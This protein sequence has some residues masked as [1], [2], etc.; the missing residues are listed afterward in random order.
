MAKAVEVRG[1]TVLLSKVFA[2]KEWLSPYNLS[3]NVCIY[4]AHTMHSLSLH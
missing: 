1:G 4:R 3:L 2:D